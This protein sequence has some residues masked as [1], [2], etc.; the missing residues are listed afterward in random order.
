MEAYIVSAYRT[1][2]GKAKKGTLRHVR[3]DDLGVAVIQHLMRQH[4]QIRP[5][6]V[7]DVVTG[8]AV[9]EGEQGLQIGRLVALR[10]LGIDVPGVTVN[11]Y[12]GSG[13]EAIA[14]AVAK[15]RAGMGH[16]YI[17][18]GIESMSMVPMTGYKFAPNYI[19]GSEH[20]DYLVSMGLTAEAL[21][22][23]YGISREEQDAFALRSHRRA[24]QA[25]DQ[26]YFESQIVPFTVYE[27]TVEGR[28]VHTQTFEFKVDEGVRR[29]TSMEALARLKPVFK[30]DGTVTAGNASQTSDGAS[31]VLVVSEERLKEW[32][33]KPMGRMIQCAVAGVEPYYMGIGP[34]KAIPKA[35][36]WSGLRLSDIELIELNEA[37]A[38]QSLAVIREAELDP[39]IV[40][41]NGGAIALGHPLG[42]T[43]AKLT[44]QILHDLHRLDK[45]YGMVTAC[46]GGGQGIAAVFERL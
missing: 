41:I 24:A 46:I 4:P 8:C 12:C 34:V 16:C 17:A 26:G 27:K 11:R 5:E 29:D 35:L 37:F 7:D 42:C 10:A 40:N 43:G 15:I 19:F 36:K 31:Y 1:A 2:V 3:S 30:K 18:G 38:A 45:R 32:G 21:A 22:E 23:K 25:I 28:E 20:P 33:L 44:T 9:P 14:I 13:L 6:D 39:D